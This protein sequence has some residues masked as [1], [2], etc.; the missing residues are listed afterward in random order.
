MGIADDVTKLIGRPQ[1]EGLMYR[2]V[3]PSA[4]EIGQIICSLANTR[5]G[6]LVLGVV[7]NDN[8]LFISGLSE[9]FQTS[10][11]VRKAIELLSPKPLVQHDYVVYEGKRLYAIK[12]ERSAVPVRIEGRVPDALPSA[13][14]SQGV[15]FAWLHISDLHFGHGDAAHSSDQVLVTTDLRRDI[16]TVLGQGAPAPS[17]ILVTGDIAFSGHTRL[18]PGDQP[19]QEYPDAQRFLLSLG[20]VVGLDARRIFVVPGNHDVQRPADK[21]RNIRRLRDELRE[22]KEP[23]DVALAHIEDRNLLAQR[24]AN[25][26]AFSASFAPACLDAGGGAAPEQ[27]LWW[28]HREQA[29]SGL[30]LRLIGLN[31]ALL[32]ADE[33]D[34]G[35]L[36]LGKAPLAEVLTAPPTEPDELVVVL[37]HHPFQG[38]W[39]RDEKEIDAWVRSHAHL[40]L[41]GHV[42]EADSEEA[43]SGAGGAFVRVAAGAAH[44]EQDAPEAHGYNVAAVI[45][46]PKGELRLR[47]WPRRWSGKNKAFRPDTDNLPDGQLF[48]EHVL[49]LRL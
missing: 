40:H 1:D 32:A 14:S 9:D 49:R 36:A 31:T 18:R 37:S 30:K 26:L 13:H 44:G 39:L 23:L 3:L 7:E 45:R 43:R 41:F 2:A 6:F 47:L 22:G 27:R 4:R 15:L 16:A 5:G 25:Y 48:A 21:V 34:Q 38:G 28:W 20:Q 46:G 17:A 35:R 11:I 42:H 33:Q 10:A 24:Q 29:S 19:S 8:G 12:V